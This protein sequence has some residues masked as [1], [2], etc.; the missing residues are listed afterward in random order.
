MLEIFQLRKS[1]EKNKTVLSDVCLRLNEAEVFGLVGINGA[2]KSTLLRLIAGVL[3]A[4][5][6]QVCIDGE[7]VYEN[8]CKKAQMFFVPD[9]P[10][11]TTGMTIGALVSAYTATYTLNKGVLEEY[12]EKFHLNEKMPL[13]N[14][15]KGMKR[16]AFVA[17]ALAVEP[18][19]LLLDEAF[20]G[21]DP[22]ARIVFREGI[23]RLVREKGTTVIISSHSLRELQGVCDNYGILDGGRLTRADEIEEDLSK[24]H[25]WQIALPSGVT[26]EK[27]NLGFA[28]ISLTQTGRVAQLIV[29]GDKE[30]VEQKLQAFSPIFVEELDVDFEE[31]FFGAVRAKGY[32][33]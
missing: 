17:L 21:L 6:G 18:K 33:P 3:R 22:L 23:K 16:Q 14:L 27:E 10:F 32:L 29:A 7:N 26:L 24:L 5:S 31:L 8:E 28:C 25:K 4:D 9:E 19:Y 2:G 15:S 1:Y 30:D 11:F 20:D 12:L 13:R